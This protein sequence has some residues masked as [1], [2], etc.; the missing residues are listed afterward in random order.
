MIWNIIWYIYIHLS[1]LYYGGV[2]SMSSWRSRCV[3]T[4]IT[5]L[6][7]LGAISE[8]TRGHCKVRPRIKWLV[9]FWEWT[10]PFVHRANSNLDM[11]GTLIWEAWRMC[12]DREPGW[13][14]A[15]EPFAPN[16]ARVLL[17]GHRCQVTTGDRDKPHSM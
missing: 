6:R 12:R 7:C 5:S 17:Q 3:G 4:P 13:W 2:A 14:C 8:W 10:S 1:G 11:F 16:L 9:N 15:T